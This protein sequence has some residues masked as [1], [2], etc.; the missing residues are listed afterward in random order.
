MDCTGAHYVLQCMWMNHPNQVS[1]LQGSHGVNCDILADDNL[2][3]GTGWQ[4]SRQNWMPAAVV[5]QRIRMESSS[6][7]N[8][9]AA[10]LHSF[11]FPSRVLVFQRLAAALCGAF[12]TSKGTPFHI[13]AWRLSVCSWVI[14]QHTRRKPSQ[15]G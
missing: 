14:E 7:Y 15:I 6:L 12:R 9:E 2:G 1:S 13:F 3:N 8:V 4:Q 10:S 11:C 5:G